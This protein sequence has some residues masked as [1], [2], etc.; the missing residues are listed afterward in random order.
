M[1]TEL[2]N[3]ITN[4]QKDKALAKSNQE[5]SVHQNKNMVPGTRHKDYIKVKAFIYCKCFSKQ[6]VCIVRKLTVPLT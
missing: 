6:C 5:C 4:E 3:K 1:E 2:I